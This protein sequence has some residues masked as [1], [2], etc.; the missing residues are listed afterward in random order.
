MDEKEKWGSVAS[1]LMGTSR[2]V[3]FV[4]N[5]ALRVR[6]RSLAA[7]SSALSCS[8]SETS[9]LSDWS[10]GA[11]TE[12]FWARTKSL[13]FSCSSSATRLERNENMG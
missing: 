2:A 5:W 1:T 4:A 10:C 9:S 6:S 13:A 3:A 11:E 7:A 8:T 12:P